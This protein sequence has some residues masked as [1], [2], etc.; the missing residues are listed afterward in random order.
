MSVHVMPSQEDINSLQHFVCISIH[1]SHPSVST[2]D[3]ELTVYRSTVFS[4]KLPAPNSR[5][6]IAGSWAELDLTMAILMAQIKPASPFLSCLVSVAP[7]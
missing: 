5:A 3:L 2:T 7:V 1:I 4:L 6:H